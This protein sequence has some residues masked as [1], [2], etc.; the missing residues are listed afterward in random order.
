MAIATSVRDFMAE[1]G[2]RYDVL[3]HPHSHNSS[4]TAQY[5][6]VPGDALVKCVVL[7]DE[8]GYLMAVLP[9]TRHV[10]F[11]MLAKALDG[12]A[13]LVNEDE[14]SRL[15][16]DCEPGAIPPLGAVYG[17]RMVVD[18]S[19]AEQEEIYFE[20]GDHERVIQMSREDFLAMMAMEHAATAHFGAQVWRHH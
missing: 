6:H 5:A 7:E 2:L 12:R 10:Q 18:D 17:M 16:T 14:L 9:T 19:L 3:S 11:G 13:R 8:R 20:A 1:H 4:Q 15:F